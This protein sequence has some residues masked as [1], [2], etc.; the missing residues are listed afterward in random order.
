MQAGTYT[1]PT[2]GLP[3]LGRTMNGLLP[4]GDVTTPADLRAL[5]GRIV[6]VKSSRNRRNP[7]TAARGWIEVHEKPDAPPEISIAIEFPQMFST[8]AHRRSI[9][10]DD[11]TIGRLLAFND[12]RPFEFTIDDELV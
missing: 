5:N 8:P 3:V 12:D 7:P 4:K 10:L 9:P 1:E 6:L 2:S 11:A